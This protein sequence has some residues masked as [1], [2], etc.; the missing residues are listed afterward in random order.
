MATGPFVLFSSGVGE[1]RM[2]RQRSLPSVPGSVSSPAKKSKTTPCTVE[3]RLPNATMSVRSIAASSKSEANGNGRGFCSAA[4]QFEARHQFER[5]RS[6]SY[7]A[8][9]I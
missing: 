1:K 4:P 7:F 9:S 5:N 8:N 6:I 3:T 2:L